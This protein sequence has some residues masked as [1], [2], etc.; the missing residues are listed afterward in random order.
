MNKGLIDYLKHAGSAAIVGVFVYYV[1]PTQRLDVLIC[2]LSTYLY[3][4]L[5]SKIES[6]NNQGER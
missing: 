5:W 2:G 3:L 6:I 1:G 4:R